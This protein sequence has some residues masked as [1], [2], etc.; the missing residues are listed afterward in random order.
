V[1]GGAERGKGHLLRVAELAQRK[2]TRFRLTPDADALAT[3]AADSGA[4][5]LSALKLEGEM[6][7]QGRHDWTLDAQLTGT[8]V[9]ACIVTLAPVTTRL[10]ETVRRR[11]LADWQPPA[12]DEAEMPEDDT[13]EALPPV[14]DLMAV[15]AESLALSLPLYPRAPGAELGQA[16]FAEPGTAPLTDDVLRPFAG[17]SALKDRLAGPKDGDN[18]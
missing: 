14:I 1:G 9:Q 11:F 12:E 5:S 2:P 7:P 15:L 18:D 10:N 4:E 3:L 16:V 13:T 17:L 6:R 8:A